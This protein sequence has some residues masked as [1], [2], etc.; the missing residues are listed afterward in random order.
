[1]PV[2]HL[3]SAAAAA[4]LAATLAL[5]GCDRLIDGRA[6]V[7]SRNA[8]PAYFFAGDVAIYGQTVSDNDKTALAY[9]RALRRIDVCG[10]LNHDA[11]AK[12]GEILSVGTLFA[13]NE[14]D[15]DVKVSGAATRKFASVELVM[16]SQPG[17]AVAFRIGD[18]PIYKNLPGGC[19]YLVPLQLARLPGAHPLHKPQQPFVRVG[20]IADNDCGTA[21][22]IAA[23]VAEWLGKGPLPARDAAAVYPAPLAERDPCEVL[24]G[25]GGDVDRWDIGSSQ[26]HQC[27]FGL[28]MSGSGDVLSVQVQLEPLLVDT[29]TVGRDRSERNGVEIYLDRRF[30][31]AVSFVGPPMRRRIIGGGYVELPNSV[32]RP[33]VVV[34]GK[35]STDCDAVADLTTRAAKLYG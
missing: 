27:R 29:I 2:R 17:N 24:A 19:E 11:L 33:A 1:M 26:P 10:L 20:L 5:T 3:V 6:A 35:G 9:L 21:Q 13:F 12:V 18:T 34:D 23:A 31:S 28:W 15:I 22:R 14:C 4:L 32:V 8:D 16:S 30:C 7:G 25:L